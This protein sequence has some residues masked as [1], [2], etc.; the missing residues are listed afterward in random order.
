LSK[1]YTIYGRFIQSACILVVKT[2]KFINADKRLSF[3][4]LILGV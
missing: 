2:F 1:S 4:V 3:W